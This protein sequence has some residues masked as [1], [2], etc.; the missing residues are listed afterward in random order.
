M[1]SLRSIISVR[2]L[3]RGC[4]N[5]L[6]IRGSTILCLLFLREQIE[7]RFETYCVIDEYCVYF[8]DMFQIFFSPTFCMSIL[9]DLTDCMLVAPKVSNAC[10]HMW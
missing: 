3:V 7:L 8:V 6:W 5:L 10:M 4:N 9:L 1:Y 2:D